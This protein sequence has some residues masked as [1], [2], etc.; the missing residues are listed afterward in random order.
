MSTATIAIRHNQQLIRPQAKLKLGPVS[1]GIMVTAVIAVLALLYLN[2]I[3]KTSVFGYQLTE[4]QTM[5]SKVS[6][7]RQEL[8]VEAARLQSIQ[9]VQS[10]N[11]VKTMVPEG[12]VSY[13][14]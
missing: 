10:S 9:Q 2:Q 8:A 11:V 7:Q 4:L 13:A 5:Q 14:K 12:P 6:R 1:S 3:T